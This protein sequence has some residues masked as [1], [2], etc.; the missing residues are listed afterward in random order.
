LKA[1]VFLKYEL[2][3]PIFKKL[4]PKLVLNKLLSIF[5]RLMTIKGRKI[6]EQALKAPAWLEWDKLESL[7]QKYPYTP[8]YRYD[9]QS[10]EKRGRERAKEIFNLIGT[11]IG[12]FE[13]FLELGCFDGMVSCVLQRMGK[14]AIAID[15][16][17]EGFDKR[18]ID[19]G[20]IFL[21][22]DV[23]H[24]G[25]HD[26]TF[27]FIFSYNAFEHFAEPELVLQEAIRM[28]K[29]GGYLYLSFGPL[30]MS[31]RGLHAYPSITFPYCQ[32]LFPEEMLE[33]FVKLK[34]LA[35]ISFTAI[36]HLSL[37]DYRQLWDRY[38]HRL[39]KVKYYEVPNVFH[40]DLIMKYPSC[41]RSKT[42]NF[43]NLI[44][45]TIEV[46]FRKVK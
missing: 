19:G 39:K 15:I 17:C 36:N 32:F 26:K 45:S 42:E 30:Y 8:R 35:P 18:A 21:Q 41:F 23:T 6:F 14:T 12:R 9:P 31:P 46:L 16:K 3:S 33:R 13:N 38:S 11:E 25:F 28:L 43:D 2:Y 10:V 29:T 5:A 22:M 34:R 40:L 24:L 37:E 27:D 44:I 1:K 20:T 4:I 7:Q